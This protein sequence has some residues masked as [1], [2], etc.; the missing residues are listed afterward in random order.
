MAVAAVPSY[1]G[2]DFTDAPPGHHFGLYF[3][4][5]D[6]HW[7][8]PDKEKHGA[9]K[10][11][12]ALNDTSRT[13]LNGLR[14]RQKALADTIGDSVWRWP[15]RS[16]APFMTG[17]GNEH[18]LENGFS[19]L[20]PYGLPYLPGSG[21]KGVL[22]R[23][24]EELTLGLYDGDTGGWDVVSL[25]WL[26]GFEPNSVYL[27]GPSDRMPPT[28]R[29][30][31][32]HWQDA[33]RNPATRDAI[34]HD[35][36][37]ALIEA[38]L[39]GEQRRRYREQPFLLLDELLDNQKLRDELRNRG[40]L[41]FWDVIPE[42]ASGKLAVD[43]MTPH[44]GD[45]YQGDATPHDSGQPNPILFLTIPP[46]SCFEFFVQC[47]PAALPASLKNSWPILLKAAFQLAFEWLG[48]GAKTAVGYGAM[49]L[50]EEA[51]SRRVEAQ[52]K[53]EDEVAKAAMSMEQRA[54]DELNGWFNE[55]K[56]AS[57]K[58]PGGRLANRLNE[59]LKEALPW[60]VEERKDLAKLAEEIYGY[61]GWGNSKKKQERKSR[62][63]KLMEGS[64]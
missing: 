38:T 26:F 57:K 39:N 54:I 36:L 7:K 6:Q 52:Q 55:D 9:L 47:D 48:F 12:T 33:Y 30:E 62:I 58:E 51:E 32:Q 27:T 28:Q 41:M 40:A 43:I 16:I 24:A 10:R 18:P 14:S 2:C 63:R 44:Y 37:E 53:R 22:R 19:F 25:W 21:V 50:D 5:W 1:M 46:G 4:V 34:P 56:Q 20:T 11:V 23:A 8:I 60:P 35:R 29:E 61:L 64:P 59:L 49:Q 42:S 17:L 31:A 15:A 13:L 45:Y 3:D